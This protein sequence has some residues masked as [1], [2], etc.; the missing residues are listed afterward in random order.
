SLTLRRVTEVCKEVRMLKEDQNSFKVSLIS[1]PAEMLTMCL[2]VL[3][4]PEHLQPSSLIEP[5]L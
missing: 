1:E 4:L 2:R 3:L 5:D